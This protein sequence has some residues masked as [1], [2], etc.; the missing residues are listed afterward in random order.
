MRLLDYNDWYDSY[1]ATLED[2]L[3][4]WFN[5]CPEPYML[6]ELPTV[7]D[8][9]EYKYEQYISDYSDYAYE[10]YRDEKL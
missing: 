10:S 1:G 4:D 7:E 8:Y 5:R 3:L 2:E 6:D 9:I